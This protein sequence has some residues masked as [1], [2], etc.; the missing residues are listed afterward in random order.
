MRIFD[1]HNDTLT[2]LFL[3]HD[4]PIDAFLNGGGH[5]IDLPRARQAGFGGGFFAI[6]V[7]PPMDS[8]EIDPMAGVE[9]TD[10]G[11]ITPS[12]S[13]LEQDYAEDFTDTLI[14]FAADLEMMSQGQVRIIHTFPA[15]VNALD[16]DVLAMVLHL[17]GAEAIQ[18]DLS[19]LSDYYLAG[20]RSIGL[21]WS[22]PNAFGEGVPFAFPYSPDTGGGLT[23]A[24][25]ALVAAC[26]RMGILVDLAHI[27][28]KGFWDV[29]AISTKPLVVSHTDV[30]AISPSTRNLTDAQIDAVQQSGGVI[31]VNFDAMMTNPQSDP[32]QDVPLTQITDHIEYIVNRIGIDY[33]A[34]GS[35]LDGT[36]VPNELGDITGLPRLLETLREH[37]YDEDALHKI[38]V[39]NWLRVIEATWRE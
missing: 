17:E 2:H 24:G 4:D 15:L 38:A 33:V 10:E 37:G 8:P 31:G 19:N 14:D 7:S 3:T 21:T 22:R 34:F 20:V 28:E 36:D 35:D 1:G 32:N 18:P 9:Y 39:G 13:P 5:Q 6:F 25:K 29:A 12:R 27:N 30:F 16:N 11:Y 23:E 26:N